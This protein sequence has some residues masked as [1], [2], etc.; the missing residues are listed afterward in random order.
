MSGLVGRLAALASESAAAEGC[1]LV[2]MLFNQTG[3]QPVMRVFL[4]KPDGGVT[5]ADCS[6]VSS[7]LGGLLD[8]QDLVPGKYRLEVSSPGLNR[9]L[10]KRGDFIRFCGRRAVIKTDRPLVSP[11]ASGGGDQRGVRS[12]SG[13]LSGVDGDDVVIQVDGTPVRVPLP[14]ISSAN[15]A[16]DF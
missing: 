2:E 8:L 16:F 14:W 5:L 7:R 6:A 15:L 11:G 4:D 3:S 13:K 1:E 12:V 9:P 10:K